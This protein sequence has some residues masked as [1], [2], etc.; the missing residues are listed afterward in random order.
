MNEDQMAYLADCLVKYHVSSFKVR[1][2][3]VAQSGT[4]FE[5]PV[6]IELNNFRR[7]LT[8]EYS[9]VDLLSQGVA[10]KDIV[11]RGSKRIT[12]L[13]VEAQTAENPELQL[14]EAK[15]I[16]SEMIAAEQMLEKLHG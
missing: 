4:T 9:D 7:R 16:R 3:Q 15:K 5:L 2:Y 13:V 6:A 1:T 8:S 12:E 14:K 10:L 11:D